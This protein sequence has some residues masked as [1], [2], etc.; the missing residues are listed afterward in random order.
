MEI[1]NIQS[2]CQY[3]EKRS[4]S[5]EAKRDQHSY[6]TRKKAKWRFGDL[7]SWMKK[8]KIDTVQPESYEKEAK[9][10]TKDLIIA[11]LRKKY[12]AITQM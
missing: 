7:E 9:L 10:N 3:L 12:R 5:H 6:T 11:T 1:N 2:S 4:S 8:L